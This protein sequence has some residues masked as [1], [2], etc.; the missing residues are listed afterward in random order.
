MTK[1]AEN[2]DIVSMMELSNMYMSGYGVPPSVETA[3]LWLKK[4]SAAGSDEAT[5][6]LKKMGIKP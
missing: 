6:R 5:Q 4:A 3:T 1:S 2:G